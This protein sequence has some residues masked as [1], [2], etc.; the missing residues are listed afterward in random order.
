MFVRIGSLIINC[1]CIESIGIEECVGSMSGPA[2][3]IVVKTSDTTHYPE[4]FDTK[5][6]AEEEIDW[7]YTKL[8]SI[9]NNGRG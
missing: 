6:E 8:S 5:R 1:I 7:I 3:M 4:A 9:A 2:Y